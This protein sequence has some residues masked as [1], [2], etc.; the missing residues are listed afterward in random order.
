MKIIYLIAYIGNFNFYY[1]FFF[2]CL[3]FNFFFVL[4]RESL[5]KRHYL[6]KS[7]I[8]ADDKDKLL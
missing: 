3:N 8:K 4:K 7:I 5:T 6:M 1:F 2:L